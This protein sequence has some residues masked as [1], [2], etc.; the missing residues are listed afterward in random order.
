M[1][2]YIEP[3]DLNK[4]KNNHNITY[5]KLVISFPN[6][7]PLEFKVSSLKQLTGILGIKESTLRKIVYTPGYN[8][9]KYEELFKY[10]A[11]SPQY[12]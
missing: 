11:L 12:D 4:P 9:K 1:L 7:K 2:Q 6:T 5:W 10:V 8:S 3:S